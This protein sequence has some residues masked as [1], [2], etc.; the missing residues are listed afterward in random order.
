MTIFAGFEDSRSKPVGTFEYVNNSG[1]SFVPSEAGTKLLDYFRNKYQVP[2]E[3]RNVPSYEIQ[4]RPGIRGYFR[5][6]GINSER[7]GGSLDPNRR[8][9]FL[10]PELPDAHVLAHEAGH[11]YDPALM[12]SNQQTVETRKNLVPKLA[13]EALGKVKDPV[14]FLNTFI[15]FAGPRNVMTSEVTAQKAAK[16][17][18]S[19]LNLPHPE[20]DH[21]WFQGYPRSFVDTGIGGATAALSAP[22]MPANI[23]EE[24]VGNALYNDRMPFV[25]NAVLFDT[26]TVVDVTDERARR[27]LEL[28]LDPAYTKAVSNIENRTQNY[29]NRELGDVSGNRIPTAASNFFWGGR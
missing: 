24:I 3:I 26:N 22:D 28:A 18:L 8:V 17:A 19:E 11:A 4:A 5:S 29:L 1:Y 23:K 7:Y 25:P 12:R 2:L 14:S 9:V 21:P 16:Q 13:R 27:L 15:D 10:N 20:K 6:G